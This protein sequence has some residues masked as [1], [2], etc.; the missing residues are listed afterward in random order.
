[1]TRTTAASLPLQPVRSEASIP[2]DLGIAHRRADLDW[3]RV[4]AFGL[5]IFF[6]AAMPFIPGGI[7]MIQNA[8]SSPVLQIFVGFLH[9]FRLSLLFLV[10]GVGVCF[11]LRHRSRAE[12][13]RD[14][15]IRLLVPFLFGVLV[16]VPPM[17]F[18]EKRFNGAFA[19]SFLAF[20]PRFFTEGVYPNGNLSWHQYWFIAYLY[21]FCLIG[22]PLFAWLNSVSG[23][24]RVRRWSIW[25]GAGLRLYLAI[26]PL[27]AVEI[28]LRAWFPGFRDLIH[29]W[30]SFSNWFLVFVAGFLFASSETSLDRACAIR[31]VSLSL[32][33]LTTTLL[34]FEF[35]SWSISSFTPLKDGGVRVLDYLWFCLV[36]SANAWFWLLACLG[37]AGR[38]LRRESR[39]LAY[40]NDAVYPFFCLHLTVI[41]AISYVVVPLNWP[42][43]AKYLTIAAATPV[44]VFTIY[45]GVIRRTSWLRPMVGLKPLN[46]AISS[47]LMENV[48]RVVP[49]DE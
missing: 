12:F 24:V 46:P 28:A 45:E 18:L 11:A 38:Y 44:V 25:M 39:V 32:A 19:G 22:W 20:Y 37:Y 16:I 1:M 30:A 48:G 41:V 10:S 5:L 6:H 14:R 17:I 29:D 47:P 31:G 49:N 9:E 26:L 8:E 2:T 15:A 34:F 35:W 3:L 36:R 42:V 13:F 4:V 21:L 33:C 27:A 43:M 23:R 7:P 40:L